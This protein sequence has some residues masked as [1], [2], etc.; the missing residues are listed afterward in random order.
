MR[1]LTVKKEADKT[2]L[3]IKIYAAKK[4]I[5]AAALYDEARKKLDYKL[6]II[7]KDY[8]TVLAFHADKFSAKSIIKVKF[9]KWSRQRIKVPF[10]LKNVDPR[11]LK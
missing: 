10:S 5:K 4:Q 2:V 11:D 8:Y 1:L 3:Y 9:K 7:P 6:K